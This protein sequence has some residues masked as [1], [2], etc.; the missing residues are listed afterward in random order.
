MQTPSDGPAPEL[1]IATIDIEYD[2]RRC[3]VKKAVTVPARDPNEDVGKWLDTAMLYV[4]RDHVLHSPLCP[5]RACD[6]KIPVAKDG[7]PL[8]TPRKH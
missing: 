6:V 4:A 5:S 3:G 1:A 8:G 2:C 7:D